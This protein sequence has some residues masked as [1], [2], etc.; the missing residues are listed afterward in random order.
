LRE[1][2]SLATDIFRDNL[3][4]VALCGPVVSP[5]FDPDEELTR[6]VLIVQRVDLSMLRGLA[7]HGPR[8]G[9]RGLAPPWVMTPAYLSAS[10]DVFPLELLEI[11]DHHLMLRGDDCFALLTFQ[12]AHMRLQCERELKSLTIGLGHGLLATGGRNKLINELEHQAGER[13]KRTLRGLVWLKGMKE[14]R[15]L[16]AVLDTLE[17]IVQ[18]KL[19][20]LRAAIDQY[21]DHDWEEFR[22]LYEEVEFLGETVNGW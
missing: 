15:A 1:F 21:A 12:D 22:R 11:Q 18:R 9:R 17:N 19:P 6:T 16:S 2:L 14:T 5:E 3:A 13:L 20:G 7:E 4:A 10:Q 8:L